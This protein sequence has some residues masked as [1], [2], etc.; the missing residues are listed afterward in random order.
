MIVR[1]PKIIGFMD[2][3]WIIRVDQIVPKNEDFWKQFLKRSFTIQGLDFTD[4]EFFQKLFPLI[5]VPFIIY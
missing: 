1:K 4:L 2:M 5:H 3:Y